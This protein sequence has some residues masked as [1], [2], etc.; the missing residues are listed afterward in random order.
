MLIDGLLPDGL[1]LFCKENKVALDIIDKESAIKN[2]NEIK[3]FLKTT[4]YKDAPIIPISAQQG[5]NVD[6]LLKTI[7]E[8]FPT[9]K[10]DKKISGD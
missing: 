2:Y 5:V 10:R 6:V 7:Q 9:P 3:E 1:T 4:S 8:V